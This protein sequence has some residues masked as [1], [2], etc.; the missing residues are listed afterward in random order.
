MQQHN[1]QLNK[2]NKTVIDNGRVFASPMAAAISSSWD[3]LKH[4]IY[5]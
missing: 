1:Y 5:P 4:K 3:Y 2:S